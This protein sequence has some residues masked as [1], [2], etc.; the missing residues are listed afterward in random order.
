M[1]KYLIYILL[2]PI[3]VAAQSISF[4]TV[5]VQD[6]SGIEVTVIHSQPGGT[7]GTISQMTSGIPADRGQGTSTVFSQNN[8]DQGSVVIT[9]PSGYQP[10]IGGTSYST[11]KLHA[12]AWMAFPTTNYNS[13]ASSAAAPN[14]PT[15]HFTSVNN[16]YTDNNMSHVSTE[17]Y[18][19]S[20]L[21]D[22]FRIR[23]EGSY[24]YNVSGINTK[25][26]IYFAKNNNKEILV[27]LRQ[28]LADGSNIEQIGLSNGSSWLAS[29]LI[30]T[31][32]YSSGQAWLIDNTV[33]AGVQDTLATQI[34]TSAGIVSFSN[35]NNYDYEVI[36]DASGMQSYIG[37]TE[38]NYLMYI[39]MFPNEMASWDFH[40][41][42][43]NGNNS[44]DYIDVVEAYGHYSTSDP[45][46]ENAI[47][48]QSEKDDIEV[49][50]TTFNY[51]TKYPRSDIRTF[52]N[53]NRFYIVTL[54]KHRRTINA[55]Q[56]TQ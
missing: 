17:T 12:N 18:N 53:L 10:S 16:G 41:C 49:N 30:S 24:K 39:R 8:S 48:N 33:L 32:N 40:T 47:Y 55:K 6:K 4:A 36:V 35:P 44:V 25:I 54:G 45:V 3:G 29:N 9:F 22:V 46:I 31:A 23:Y 52:S 27:V 1:I 11:G 56:I 28:F 13:Y 50:A 7:V 43:F 20:S 19:D 42:D 14:V 15:L 5:G 38:M 21:G 2:F 51:H 37:T 26:D 34:T